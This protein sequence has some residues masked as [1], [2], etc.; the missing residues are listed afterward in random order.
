MRKCNKSLNFN[1]IYR[2]II[3]VVIEYLYLKRFIRNLKIDFIFL[4]RIKFFCKII[5]KYFCDLILISYYYIN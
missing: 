5:F 1:I 4:K 3:L 2:V